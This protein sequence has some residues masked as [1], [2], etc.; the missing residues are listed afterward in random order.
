LAN[1]QTFTATVHSG[2][3]DE[4][5]ILVRLRPDGTAEVIASPGMTKPVIVTA[6]SPITLS[7]AMPYTPDRQPLRVSIVRDMP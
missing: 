1:A 4:F 3:F 5:T 7:L 6:A 2:T